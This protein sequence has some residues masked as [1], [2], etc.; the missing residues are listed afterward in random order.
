MRYHSPEAEQYWRSVYWSAWLQHP[1]HVIAT[2]LFRWKLILTNYEAWVWPPFADLGWLVT[3]GPYLLAAGAL[4]LWRRRRSADILLLVGPLCY[5]LVVGGL[6]YVE[7]RYVRYAHLSFLLGAAM[8]LD[9]AIVSLARLTP[10]AYR[11]VLNAAA[12]AA[13]VALA[14]W[15]ASGQ[16][17]GLREAAHLAARARP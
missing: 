15:W 7:P 8:T 16:T 9:G 13:L 3:A 12:A 11:R 10:L 6:I 5:A 14:L 4:V 2:I 17:A 1:W